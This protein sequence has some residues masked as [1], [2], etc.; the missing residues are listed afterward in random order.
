ME[1]NL[2]KARET[3]VNCIVKDGQEFILNDGKIIRVKTSRKI[4]RKIIKSGM[5]SDWVLDEKN[6]LDTIKDFE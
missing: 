6:Y 3:V 2:E 5:F 1:K 4:A